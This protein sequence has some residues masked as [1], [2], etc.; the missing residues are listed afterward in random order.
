LAS[1]VASR[2]ICSHFISAAS[3]RTMDAFCCCAMA[4][5]INFASCS[6]FVRCLLA[7]RHG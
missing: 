7:T 3:V 4:C 2:H 6:Q 1:N 5:A